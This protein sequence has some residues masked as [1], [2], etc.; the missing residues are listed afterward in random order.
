MNQQQ[1]V[2]PTPPTVDFNPEFR[3]L[4]ATW[5][6]GDDPSQTPPILLVWNDGALGT[7]AEFRRHQ[8]D[9]HLF[10]Q[11]GSGEIE[12]HICPDIVATV[13]FDEDLNDWVIRGP[14]VETAVLDLHDPD[15]SDDDVVSL[16]CTRNIV[17]NAKIIRRKR[18]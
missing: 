9:T 8:A 12:Q 11:N 4:I 6:R 17:Y 16:V 7:L 5:K 15:A 10:R 3:R 13:E 2:P 1:N 14:G 18:E